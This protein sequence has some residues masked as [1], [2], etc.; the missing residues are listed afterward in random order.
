MKRNGQRQT[1]EE[2]AEELISVVVRHAMHAGATIEQLESETGRGREE[3][4]RLLER[5]QELE[6]LENLSRE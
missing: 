2:N 6:Q 3:I 4:E 1:R 5:L